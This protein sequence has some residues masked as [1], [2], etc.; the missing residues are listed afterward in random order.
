MT[1]VSEIVQLW[2][3]STVAAA[4]SRSVFVSPALII[5]S[6]APPGP[7]N[8]AENSFCLKLTCQVNHHHSVC[9]LVLWAP[10]QRANSSFQMNNS[11]EDSGVLPGARSLWK[12]P[13]PQCMPLC[14]D[15]LCTEDSGLVWH[16]STIFTSHLPW[17]TSREQPKSS[18][19]AGSSPGVR[20]VM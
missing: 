13:W 4:A 18:S 9:E 7:Q 16:Y 17:R 14:A 12:E 15:S 6:A 20:R 2:T 19:C 3:S 1:R 5:C 11:Q 10:N 8:Y